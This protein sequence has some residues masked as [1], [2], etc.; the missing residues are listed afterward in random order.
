MN[1]S[2]IVA[3]LITVN[4]LFITAAFAAQLDKIHFIKIS[5]QDSKAVIRA[6]DGKML[7]VKPGDTIAENTVI[8]EITPDRI[9]LEEKTTN[10]PE[11]IIVRLDPGKTRIE[12]LRRQP[13]K[14]P[15]LVAPANPVK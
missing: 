11:T 7:V 15:M 5:A 1:L 3:Q 13:D 12:R 4:L 6:S 14:S 9:I 2:S 10:G 8:K